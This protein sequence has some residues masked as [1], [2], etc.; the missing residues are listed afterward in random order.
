M[1][2]ELLLDVKVVSKL[3]SHSYLIKNQEYGSQ[4]TL[5][6]C[7]RH[8]KNLARAGQIIRQRIIGKG[9]ENGGQSKKKKV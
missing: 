8:L 3:V 9:K 4:G 5:F 7:E 2:A 1:V 6:C